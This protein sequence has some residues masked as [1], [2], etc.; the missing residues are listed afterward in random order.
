MESKRPLSPEARSIIN[1]Q[2]SRR[3]LIAGAG[4]LGAAGLLTACGGGSS[5]GAASEGTV[6]WANWTL[7]LDY[8]SDAQAYP[9]LEKFIAE[10]GINVDYKEDYNDNDEFWGKVQGQLKLGEDIGYDIVA[11]TDWMAGRWIRMG[12]AQAFDEA[13]IPNK[14]N[15]LDALANVNFDPGRKSSLTWQSGFGG[16]GWNKEK[17]PGGIKTLDQLFSKENKGKVEVLS[18]LRDTIGIILQYQGVDPSQNFTENQYMNAV[19]YLAKMIKDGF[20]RQVKG[21]DYKEDLISGDATAV[22][23]WSG[24]IF[25][26]ATENDGKF[27]FAIPESGGM[28]WSDN[29][30]IPSTSTNKANAEKVINNYYDPAVAAEVA[31]YVTYICPVKGAQAEMEKIDPALAASPFIFPTAETLKE[32]KVFRGLTPAEET[33]FTTAFQE[34]AGN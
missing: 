13:N 24:D 15:I 21:N 18:E 25:Q 4:G 33:S 23:G 20:I 9:T 26:L 27:E 14:V 29:L 17:I 11:P 22:I 8:D 1:S 3:A 16:F 2:M 31:A 5:S 32:V 10:S 28:L 34:A 12:Y 19:D 6:R 30:L 7:Y